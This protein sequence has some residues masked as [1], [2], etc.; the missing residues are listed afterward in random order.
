MEWHYL[1]PFGTFP[2]WFRLRVFVGNL[3]WSESKIGFRSA[4]ADN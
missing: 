2:E 4:K 3:G 1:T